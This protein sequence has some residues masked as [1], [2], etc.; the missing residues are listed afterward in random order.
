MSE[1]KVKINLATKRKYRIKGDTMN[2]E[3]LE[4]L[5]RLSILREKLARVSGLAKKSG[6]SKVTSK[7]I[8]QIIRTTR[9]R[10][11]SSH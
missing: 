10:A 4:K 11:K 6:L 2:F 8:D 1:L 9:Q 3:E 7:E 5:I